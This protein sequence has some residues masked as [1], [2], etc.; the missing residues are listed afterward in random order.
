MVEQLGLKPRTSA[1]QRQRS[2]Q[3]SYCP[4]SYYFI[5]N[6]KKVNLS[7]KLVL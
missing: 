6:P 7:T 2:N 1:L 3:L 5:E 4:S